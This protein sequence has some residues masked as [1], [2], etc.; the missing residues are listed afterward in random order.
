MTDG[1]KLGRIIFYLESK[2]MGYLRLE[3][4]REEFHFRG[5]NVMSG[6]LKKGDLVYFKL[7]DGKQG[8]FADEIRKAGLA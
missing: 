6:N 3:G 2:G 1:Q 5:K 4:T 8:W 7:R